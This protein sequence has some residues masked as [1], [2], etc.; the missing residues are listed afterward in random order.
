MG[1]PSPGGDV[2]GM[3]PSSPV[4]DL[5]RGEPSSGADEAPARRQTGMLNRDLG[6]AST[7]T[8]PD[9][10]M[11]G[12]SRRSTSTHGMDKIS[13]AHLRHAQS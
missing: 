10:R 9:V 4:A 2:T 6:A 3:S 12:L 11:H 1:D 13:S 7:G 5:C 8:H